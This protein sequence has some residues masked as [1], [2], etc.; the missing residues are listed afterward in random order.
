MMQV[1]SKGQGGH[2][3]FQLSPLRAGHNRSCF[4]CGEV[5]FLEGCELLYVGDLN[6]SSTPLLIPAMDHAPL[7]KGHSRFMLPSLYTVPISVFL[8]AFLLLPVPLNPDTG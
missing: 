8:S 2:F 4:G 6:T 3:F 5:V 7:I 1:Y